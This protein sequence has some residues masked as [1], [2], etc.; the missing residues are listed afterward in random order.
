MDY[1]SFSFCSGLVCFLYSYDAG[2]TMIRKAH[3]GLLSYADIGPQ[4]SSFISVLK[5]GHV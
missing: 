5:V 3:E 1:E 2:C 4:F